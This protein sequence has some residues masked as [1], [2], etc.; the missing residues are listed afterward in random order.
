MAKYTVKLKNPQDF[1]LDHIFDCGQCFRWE[2]EED[3]SYTGIAFG[4]PVNMSIG[5]D[6]DGTAPL[7]PKEAMRRTQLRAAISDVTQYT[8]HKDVFLTI[9]N[10]TLEDYK[11]IWAPYLDLDRDYSAIKAELAERDEVIKK[12]IEF[13]SGIRI[14]RQ[15]LWEAL[16]SFVVSQNNNIPRIKGCIE[17]LATEFGT[18]AGVY[19]GREFYNIP[20]PEVL[21]SLCIED[22]AP[23]RLGYRARYIIDVAKAVVSF[24]LPENYAQLVALTG[25]GPKVASCVALFGLHDMAS[26]PIDVWVRRVMNQLYDI[27]E[28]DTRQMNAL[29]KRAFG[30]YGGIAQQYLF[31]Y[32]RS[33]GM[34]LTKEKGLAKDMRRARLARNTD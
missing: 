5:Y 21:S 28:K 13:G 15:D 7:S 31:Y 4:K 6:E 9:D 17:S 34:D 25:V 2:K 27:D 1:N 3:G 20:A 11:N 16:I 32:I 14:L 33:L 29:A 30:Q 12:A 19:C 24:G 10:A 26:F 18:A 22:L 8:R 23:I